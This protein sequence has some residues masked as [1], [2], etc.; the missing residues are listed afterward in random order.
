MTL[1]DSALGCASTSRGQVRRGA[2]EN[3][4]AFSK[5]ARRLL[6]AESP[7]QLSLV[8]A[9]PAAKAALP[10]FITKLVVRSA[11]GAAVR[12]ESTPPAR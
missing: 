12:A 8:H 1:L 10:R 6:P 9:R 4:L 7:L 2:R 5:A 3:P 11:S